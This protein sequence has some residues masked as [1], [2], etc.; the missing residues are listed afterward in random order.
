M[1]VAGLGCC[2]E[3]VEEAFL[4][5]VDDADADVEEADAEAAG[6]RDVTG[7]E[8]AVDDG[9]GEGFTDDAPRRGVDAVD[10]G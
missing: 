9:D 7:F 4:A 1:L 8:V 5:D 3:G 6:E 2:E 10:D